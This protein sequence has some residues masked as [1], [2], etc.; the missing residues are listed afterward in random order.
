MLMTIDTNISTSKVKP[1]GW[2]IQYLINPK[3]KEDLE[4]GTI[5]ANGHEVNIIQIYRRV[6]QV[7]SEWVLIG[8]FS[9]EHEYNMY[10]FRDIT[11]KNGTTYEY[12]VVP[13]AE[14]IIGETSLSNPATIDYSGVYISDSENNFK[15]EVD[16]GLGQVSHNRNSAELKPLN[17]QFPILV[18]G[19]QNYRSGEVNFLPVSETQLKTGGAAMIDGNEERELRDKLT[20]FLNNGKAKVL[21]NDNGD[22]MVVAITEVSTTPKENALMDIHAAKFKYTE[23]GK[24]DSATLSRVGLVGSVT[25]STYSFDEYGGII[26]DI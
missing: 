8:Q 4:A 13:V 6:Y 10:S 19:A 22:I 2:N 20:A 25:K 26:W 11:A 5:D 1:T 12:A 17:S 14:E 18:Y 15:L 21:R 3:F 7:Q 16:F 9:Y 24:V 23:I